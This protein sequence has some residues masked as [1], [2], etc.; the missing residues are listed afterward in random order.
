MDQGYFWLKL[1]DVTVCRI[2]QY[3]QNSSSNL[4]CI[5]LGLTQLSPLRIDTMPGIWLVLKN[6]LSKYLTTDSINM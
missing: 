5:I 1:Q 3:P 4:I 6:M 2:A